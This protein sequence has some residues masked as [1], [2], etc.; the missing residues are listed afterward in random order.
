V[1]GATHAQVTVTALGAITLDS[2][3]FA[4]RLHV[5]IPYV[6][7]L[8]TLPL[9]AFTQS[10]ELRL[11]EKAIAAVGVEADEFRGMFVGHKRDQMTEMQER[12]VSSEF[13]TISPEN[14]MM[15]ERVTG[16]YARQINVIVQQRDPLPLTVQAIIGTL[17]IGGNQ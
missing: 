2:G 13:E 3:V 5:G 11:S 16:G 7:E 6:S 10:A 12:N 4:E 8:V 14:K 9:D 17:E 15:V 1:D